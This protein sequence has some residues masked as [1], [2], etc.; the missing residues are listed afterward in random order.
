MKQPAQKFMF[1]KNFR[2]EG[3]P[4]PLTETTAEVINQS[5]LSNAFNDGMIA[6]RTEAQAQYE[7]I[8]AQAQ[9]SIATQM[10]E[11]SRKLDQDI[12]A[13]EERSGQIALHFARKLTTQMIDREPTALIEA[14]FVK[15]LALAGQTPSLTVNASP[16]I[17]N[18]LQ[19][20]L[21]TK[22]LENGY[23]GEILVLPN[24][25]LS[26]SAVAIEW[27]E[28]GLNFDPERILQEVE[29]F[30]MTYFQSEPNVRE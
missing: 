26:G 13:I 10:A 22:A 29:S 15:C 25:A 23:R 11:I 6:G 24:P 19:S 20:I 14:A 27:S 5:A 8:L 18:D 9:A 12:R 7:A 4:K 3:E 28:G 30:T 2:P 1:N 16:E 21:A 17:V